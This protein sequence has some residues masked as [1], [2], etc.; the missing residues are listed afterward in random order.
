[1]KKIISVL[2][3]LGVLLVI[4]AVAI[5]FL[6]DANQFRPTLESRLTQALHRDVKI[7]GLKLAI[8]SGAVSASGVSI[9]DDP[10][11]NKTAF[12]RASSLKAG[13]DLMALILS[14]KLNVTGIELDQP[15]ID[16]VQNAGGAWNFS[17]LGGTPETSPS[18]PAPPAAASSTPDLSIAAIKV[19][20]GRLTLTRLGGQ[21]PPIVLDKV[22]ADLK[23]FAPA[24]SFPFSLSAALAGGGTIRLDGKAGP[25]HAGDAISTP[26]DAKLGIVHLDLVASG[27]M[28]P[29]T[30]VSGIV[31][32]DGAAASNHA[33]IT[34][35]GKL[36]G[37]QLKLVKG[38]RP[39]K[40]PVELNFA[41]EHDLKR[42]GGVIKRADVH[43]GKAVATLTGSYQLRSEGPGVNL[44]LVGSKMDLTELAAMLPALDIVL[45]AGAEIDQG[46]ADV[47]LEAQGPLDRIAAT[48]SFSL[49]N[50][51]LAKFDLASKMR[52]LESLAG[53][54]AEPHT[55]IQALSAKVKYSFEGV[56]LDDIVFDAPS[57]GRITGAGTISPAH[58]LDLRM[59][60]IPRAEVA[61]LVMPG[62]KTGIPFTVTGTSDNPSIKPDVK[63]VVTDRL[64]D[65]SGANSAI[66]QA[67]GLIQGLFGGKKKQQ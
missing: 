64:K 59:R 15:Q 34:L 29:S 23:N 60:V 65:I 42:L 31:A 5:P 10:A 22:N 47:D 66:D 51:R 4:A 11:F 13:V 28:E 62:S 2:G 20:D 52:V 45:P 26:F 27:V 1:M 57:I 37:E 67:S 8:L 36:T 48:G 54:K 53:I 17:S 6:V 56:E 40:R 55:T 43:L 44:K 33:N 9:A 24:A 30:G 49:E 32:I 3:V 18:A 46:A 41:V 61:S 58:Q 25:I 50:A 35:Q 63:G 12:L 14:R 38:G 39:A 19:S 7:G 16:L 21:A